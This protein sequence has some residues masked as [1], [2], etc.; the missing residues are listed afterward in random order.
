MIWMSQANW[1]V[2]IVLSYNI[3]PVFYTLYSAHCLLWIIFYPLY[4]GKLYFDYFVW[5]LHV[6]HDIL[7][8]ALHV[9]HSLECILFL[10][11]SAVYLIHILSNAFHWVT[12]IVSIFYRNICFQVHSR[13]VKCQN[14]QKFVVSK[15][16][17]V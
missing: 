10:K 17:L 13:G 5:K 11:F 4:F 1:S 9:F 8:F 12:Y 14:S 6:M 7:C 15:I 2:T 16:L 3:C